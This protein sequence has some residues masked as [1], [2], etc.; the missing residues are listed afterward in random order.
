M[1][2]PAEFTR[3]RLPVTH[4]MRVDLQQRSPR[5][6]LHERPHQLPAG[7]RVSALLF[8]YAQ[9]H[10]YACSPPSGIPEYSIG[11]ADAAL[12]II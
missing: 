10:P 12:G 4:C 7:P 6:A 9:R 5:M 3:T 1:S 8:L 11:E 2:F